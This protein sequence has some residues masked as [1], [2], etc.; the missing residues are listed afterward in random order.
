MFETPPTSEDILAAIDI[1]TNNCRLLVAR[2]LPD[3]TVPG[4]LRPEIID[5][6]SRLVRL[7]E[8]LSTATAL[9]EDAMAR[10]LEALS[11]CISKM[12]RRGTTRYRAVATESCRR[13]TNADIFVRR[14][15]ELT[16]LTLEVI[17]ATEEARLALQG[18]APLF[19][20]RFTHGLHFDIGGG[21][22]ELVW[23]QL[24]PE[25]KILAQI[26]IPCGV[27]TLTETYGADRLSP[28][29]YEAMLGEIKAQLQP[30]ATQIAVD[31]A[32]LQAED[33]VQILGCAG[34][35]STIA[36]LVLDLPFYQR[37]KVDGYH[38][39]IAAARRTFAELKQ[40]DFRG[41]ATIPALGADRADLILAG[42]AIVEAIAD[43]WHADTIRVADR[44]VREGILYDLMGLGWAANGI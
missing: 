43:T 35:I 30:L 36:A 32:R 38:L 18:C 21:S 41:R 12:H 7:G 9:T 28:A 15:A 29:A 11:V 24:Q 26:S 20:P 6:F 4:G 31:F 5:A 40:R 34:T 23:A 13:V 3:D 17:D 37:A 16:G 33:K 42:C 8:G 1:G 14:V 44:G 22:T 39:D 10:T 27:T 19:E 25:R 2:L